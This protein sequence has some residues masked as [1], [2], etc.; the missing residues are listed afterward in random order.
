[1]ENFEDF[2]SGRT[3]ENNEGIETNV[4]KWQWP[5]SDE[6]W[7]KLQAYLSQTEEREQR[8]QVYRKVQEIGEIPSC[9][10]AEQWESQWNEDLQQAGI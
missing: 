7:E 3:A 5:L 1:M 6:Q 8:L 2:K 10:D 9:M 4:E